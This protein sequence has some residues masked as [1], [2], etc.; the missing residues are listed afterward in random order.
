MIYLVSYNIV[1]LIEASAHEYSPIIIYP[2]S[3][4]GLTEYP[5]VNCRGVKPYPSLTEYFDQFEP[6]GLICP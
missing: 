5:P 1:K 4:R 3:Q 2:V 6:I